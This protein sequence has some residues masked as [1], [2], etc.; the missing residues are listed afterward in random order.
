VNELRLLVQSSIKA[1]GKRRQIRSWNDLKLK[2]RLAEKLHSRK[3]LF[4]ESEELLA[5]PTFEYEDVLFGAR[6]VSNAPRL[7]RIACLHALDHIYKGRDRV[8]KNNAR[9]SQAEDSGD[10]ELRDQGFT[11]PKVLILLETRQACHKYVEELM[12]L[13]DPEQ[14]E[15]KKRFQDGFVTEEDKF[16]EDMPEDF[17]EL[18]EGNDDN[19]FR[20]GIKFTRKTVKYFSQFYTSDIILASPLGLRRIIEHEDPKKADSD[21]L[22]SIEIA[23]VDQAD[24]MLMQNWEHVEFVFAH[25]NLQPKDAHGCDFSRVRNWYLDGRAKYF[26]QTLVFSAF[27]TPELNRLFNTSMSNISG[28]TKFSPVSLGTI[29]TL[30]LPIRQ[31]FSRYDSPNPATD[32]DARFKFFAATI[33]PS[34]TRVATIPGA[35]QGTLLFIPS[36]LDFVRLRNFFAASNATQDISF[37]AI[38]EYTSVSDSRRARSLFLA[39][40]NQVLLYTGRAH[41]FHRYRI[42]GVKKVIMYAFPE[43]PIFYAEIVG[44]FLGRSVSEGLASFDEIGVRAIFSKWDGLRLERV[45]GSERVRGMIAGGKG[46]TFDFV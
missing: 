29:T 6:T 14:Q 27:L 30:N 37:G 35:S 21:F 9:L 19:D 11:R 45:V 17:R 33:L 25:L 18:F 40:R 15:N 41:H 13:C 43:N 26:R 3:S 39:G 10:L 42:K 34:L 44:G 5:P 12:A 1:Q 28:K 2:K 7:R 31:T 20:L 38:S 46:D 32:P 23:I 4:D 36:Y 16:N 22:S 24:A 8:L